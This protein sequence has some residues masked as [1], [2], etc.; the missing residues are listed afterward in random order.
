M[1]YRQFSVGELTRLARGRG[2]SATAKGGNA[3]TSWL[4]YRR[5]GVL[6]NPRARDAATGAGMAC[7]LFLSAITAGLPF[8]RQRSRL[9]GF[10]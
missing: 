8:A 5:A 7:S 1:L 9:T 3:A 10:A 2:H 4:G 6:A